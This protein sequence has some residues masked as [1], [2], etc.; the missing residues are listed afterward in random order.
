MA[1]SRTERRNLL[2]GLAFLSPWMIG[3][4]F[5]T[6]IPVCLAIY[7]SF[8]DYSLLQRPLYRGLGNYQS[9]LHDELFWLS[10]RNTL[11]YAAMALPAGMMVSLGLA[12]LLNSNV[13]GLGFYRSLIFLPSLV[14][15]VAS[16]VLWAWI[17]NSKLGLLNSMLRTFGI[18]GPVWLSRNVAMPSLAM[19]SL[20]GVG[21][22]V[23]IYLAGLQDIPKELYEAAEI[24]GAGWWGRLRHV[25]LPMLSP[26]IFFNLVL[27]IIG[28]FQ[29]PTT[30]YVLTG[31]G[32][33][34]ATYFYSMYLYENA[35]LFLKMGYA[36]AMAVILLL[37]VISLTGT[38]FWTSRRWVYYQGK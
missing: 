1:N 17:Y 9:L 13:R 33:G 25:T 36:S 6:L 21:N 7:Y 2:K 19:M 3:F 16:G 18:D 22:T 4:C 32:P 8:C 24:D 31:G 28:I 15:T 30:A 20:W 23:V 10:L 34:Y 29:F 14:P 11:Y 35:F 27:A 12:I 26:V 38:A 5:F 37:I